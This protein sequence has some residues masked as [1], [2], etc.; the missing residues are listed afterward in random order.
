M[1]VISGQWSVV[2]ESDIRGYRDLKIWQEG[3]YLVKSIYEVSAAF[4]KSE[5]Y[6]LTSQLR[7]AAVSIPSN[8]AEGS[9]RPTRDFIRFLGMAYG[10][11][12]ELET[13]L[14]I[15]VDL[16]YTDQESLD[17]LLA[18]TAQLGRQINGLIRSLEAKLS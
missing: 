4:P 10:S 17:L 12:M 3:R 14:F 1:S 16:H 13:Q 8:I 2:G 11:L 15:A 9:A 7:R 18:R 6:G 5:I